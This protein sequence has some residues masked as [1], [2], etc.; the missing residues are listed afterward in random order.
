MKIVFFDFIRHFGGASQLALD[1]NN[2]LSAGHEVEVIDVY[3][4]CREYI[5]AHVEAELKIHVLLTDVKEV[6][7]G[8]K[9]RKF[10]RLWRGLCQLPL[11]WL[12]ATK[13][14]KKVMEINPDVIWTTSNTGLLLLGLSLGFCRYPLVRYVCTCL[15]ANSIPSWGRWVMK[16]FA[17]LLMAISTETARQVKA[18]GV[19]EDKIKVVFDTIDFED[20]IARSKLKLQRA[21]P[22]MERRPCIVLAASLS[23]AKGQHTAIKALFHLKNRGLNPTLWIVGDRYSDDQSYVRYLHNLVTQFELCRNIHFLGWRGDVPA[24]MRESDIVILPTYTEGFGHVILE[25]MLLRRPI[26]ATYV[27]GIKDSIKNGVNGLTFPV[28]D[29]RALADCIERIISDE[30]LADSLVQNGYK[31]ITENFNPKI[32]T[33][34]VA[35]ALATVVGK[36][37]HRG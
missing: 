28:D 12:L 19:A 34:R 37:Y 10:L 2:R 5:Q 13:L 29:D 7:I 33:K 15:E 3:G 16:N 36:R 6:Y 1:V 25:G 4:V 20:T 9:N 26:V 14:R 32:H 31:T 22:G 21:L 8:Y 18:V 11:F 17:T 24:I 30:K 35:D 27:G 23:E